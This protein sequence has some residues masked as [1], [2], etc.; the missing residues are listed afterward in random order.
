MSTAR[1][2]VVD[3]HEIIAQA[4]E[5]VLRGHGH[6]VVR[7]DPVVDDLLGAVLDVDPDLVLL[8]LDLGPMG[9]SS[10][11]ITPLVEA[12][13]RVVVLT[14]VTDRRRK[15]RCLRAG[16]HAVVSKHR[17]FGELQ[18]VVLAALE[19]EDVM[20][21]NEREDELAWLRSAEAEQRHRL[22]GFDDL[23]PREAEVLGALAEGLAVDEIAQ[24]AFVAPSTVRS[25]VR[26]I[27][28]KLGV[29]SQLAAVAKARAAR[30]KPP[31]D[32]GGAQHGR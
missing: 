27:L 19:G 28:R 6:D 5:A 18:D 15:A 7:V 22:L 30:W 4:L 10:P 13:V 1:V 24:R 2:A 32:T 8:D 11:V 23:S 25:Q 14:G 31:T 20:P 16:S 21:A 26:A 17:S 12:G 9:D 29:G 3:D